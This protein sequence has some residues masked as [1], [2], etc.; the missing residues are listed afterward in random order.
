MCIPK[1][2]HYVETELNTLEHILHSIH[3]FVSPSIIL[4]AVNYHAVKESD[5]L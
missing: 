4:V 5:I 2:E 1:N 3:S